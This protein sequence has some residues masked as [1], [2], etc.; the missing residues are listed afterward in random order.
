MSARRDCAMSLFL[1]Q[2]PMS[3]SVTRL[4]VFDVDGTL[5]DS[6][7]NIVASMV[8]ACERHALPVPS[9]EAIRRIIGLSLVEATMRLLPGAEPDLIGRVVEEY[10]NGFAELRARPD[11]HEPLFPGTVEALDALEREGWI[12]AVATGKSRRG[13][14]AMIERHGFEG[15]FVSLQCADDNPGKPHPA[16][17]R[18]AIAE[19][20]AQPSETVMI[21][22]TSYDMQM[23]RGAGARAVGV[24]WG[25][26]SPE[27]LL[28]SGADLVVETYPKL[29]GSLAGLF[30]RAQ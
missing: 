9:D 12:L 14:L 8:R 5:I 2:F 30:V 3:S 16:M 7:H 17:L 4:A 26:H 15:R 11:H 27:E 24:A 10:K 29:V 13:L 21:G 20:G 19:A 18:R 22:D 1:E 25:Y 6:Q 28:A 23:G